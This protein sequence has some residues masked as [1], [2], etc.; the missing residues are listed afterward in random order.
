MKCNK[1]TSSIF[2]AFP[3][4]AVYLKQSAGQNPDSLFSNSINQD[5]DLAGDQLFRLSKYHIS[6]SGSFLQIGLN[7]LI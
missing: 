6:I 7:A 4:A 2:N 3:M 1:S 5:R